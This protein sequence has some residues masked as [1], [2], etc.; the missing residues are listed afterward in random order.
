MRLGENH[1]RRAPLISPIAGLRIELELSLTSVSFFQTRQGNRTL[2][3]PILDI[4]LHCQH[5]CDTG[6]KSVVVSRR[7]GKLSVSF[8]SERLTGKEEEEAGT[9]AFA[10]N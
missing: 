8:P 1:G 7:R 4:S 6:I 5:T 3:E 10:L 2:P 9:M